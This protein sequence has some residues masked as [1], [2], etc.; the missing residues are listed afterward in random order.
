MVANFFPSSSLLGRLSE[1]ERDNPIRIGQH[2]DK[3]NVARLTQSSRK[4]AFSETSFVRFKLTQ[5]VGR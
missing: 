5:T 1:V 4:V 3:S 2:G